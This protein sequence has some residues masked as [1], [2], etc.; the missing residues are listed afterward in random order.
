MFRGLQRKSLRVCTRNF[1]FSTAADKEAYLRAWLGTDINTNL[2]HIPPKAPK[3]DVGPPLRHASSGADIKAASSRQSVSVAS[4]DVNWSESEESI[5]GR[6][7][8]LSSPITCFMS[9]ANVP[10]SLSA[11]SVISITRK[12][13]V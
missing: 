8:K 12:L 2:R 6:F 9:L 10:S 13:K 5:V 4:I 1:L 11:D 7:D 3:N